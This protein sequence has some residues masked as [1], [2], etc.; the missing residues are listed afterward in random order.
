[1]RYRILYILIGKM[2]DAVNPHSYTISK[3]F[4]VVTAFPVLGVTVPRSRCYRSPF[5]ASGDKWL[6]D[7][8]KTL[9]II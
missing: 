6:I 9:K 8:E 3:G 5:S 4:Q 2:I 7:A 1:M